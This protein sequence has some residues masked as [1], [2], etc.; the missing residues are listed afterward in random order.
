M[1][2]AQPLTR[3][4]V[5]WYNEGTPHIYNLIT[6][7]KNGAPPLLPF[8]Y[9]PNYRGLSRSYGLPLNRSETKCTWNFRIEKISQKILK[10]MPFTHIKTFH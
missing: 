8:T 6:S 5:E 7:H 3:R 2:I 10:D 1:K 4:K 9:G